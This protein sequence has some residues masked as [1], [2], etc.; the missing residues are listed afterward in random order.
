MEEL[1]P[2]ARR[3]TIVADGPEALRG[4]ID[5]TA[6]IAAEIELAMLAVMGVGEHVPSAKGYC[7]GIAELMN[8]A[9]RDLRRIV[10]RMLKVDEARADSANQ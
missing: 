9:G 5:D 6:A 10:E 4:I 8:I 1:M 3:F 2:Q 7:D